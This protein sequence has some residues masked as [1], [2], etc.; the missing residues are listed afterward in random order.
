MVI[1]VG[2][3]PT[4]AHGICFSIKRENPEYV[5][6]LGTQESQ[7]KTMPIIK[8]DEVMKERNLSETVLS[9]PNDVESITQ[10][11]EEAIRNLKY[12][13][14]DIVIDYTSGTKA[15]STGV[16]IAGIKVKVGTLVYVS[17]DRDGRGIVIS[18]TERL[19]SLEPNRIYA[20][21][22]WIKA[23]DL[24]N[25]SQYDACIKIICEAKLLIADK[26]FQQ[27][28]STLE[29]LTETYSCWDKFELKKAFEKLAGVT[30]NEFLPAWG[31][32]SQVK[33]N[34]ES[35]YQEKDNLFC[36]ER[37]ADLIENAKRRGREGKFDDAVARLYRAIEYIA[38]YKVNEKGLYKRNKKGVP[39]PDDL[40]INAL[41]PG[42][43]S[44]YEQYWDDKDNKIK[45]SL[46]NLYELLKDLNEEIGK[47]FI[48][49]VNTKDSKLKKLLGMR[50]NSILAH[51]FNTVGES[52]F[53]KMLGIIQG[54]TKS[55]VPDLDR[56]TDKV[57]FPII[58]L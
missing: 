57:K 7:E 20:D 34:K 14:R 18:G 43:K 42:L 38:Q 50:N 2:T 9:N 13:P 31:I 12:N 53:D 35:L 19:I 23:V 40:D 4:V 55:I 36:K 10:E 52:G 30:D 11:S 45:L 28:M 48:E 32:K 44:K 15:M 6:F 26:E 3:G 47:T 16:T 54:L 1:T 27:R 25:N 33:K 24:F 58:K 29:E 21:A 49:E 56:Y 8:K 46:Y 51:G 39:Q 22:L 41:P 17:G 37:I 5:L